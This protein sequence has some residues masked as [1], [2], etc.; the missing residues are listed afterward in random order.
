LSYLGRL[1]CCTELARG[2]VTDFVPDDRG[3]LGFRN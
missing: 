2:D 1:I 3:Q